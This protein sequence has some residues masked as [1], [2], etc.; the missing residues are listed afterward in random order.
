MILAAGDYNAVGRSFSD[1]SGFQF[2]A[3]LRL[4][5]PKFDS[6]GFIVFSQAAEGSGPGI[7]P[8][9]LIGEFRRRAMPVNFAVA[10]GEFAG[11][12]GLLVVLRA[13]RQFA[14]EVFWQSVS[15]ELGAEW[16]K[17][18]MQFASGFCGRDGSGFLRDDVSGV[19]AF[20]HFH[21]G[22]AGLTVAVENGPRNR[23][24]AAV[25]G[26]KGRMH[27]EASEFGNFENFRREHLAVGGGNKKVEIQ[28]F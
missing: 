13:E 14:F 20:V 22:D 7:E 16:S 5:L 11:V 9:D 25:F 6:R 21:D 23:R 18:V 26:Q 19:E 4:G 15:K 8:A 27:V 24:G 3:G 2:G 1:S 17:S 10:P 28:F 12:R